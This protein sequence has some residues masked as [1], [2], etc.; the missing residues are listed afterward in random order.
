MDTSVGSLTD[1]YWGQF[2][3]CAPR[4][5][6]V[7]EK[8]HKSPQLT[9]RFLNT[10]SLL[11]HIGFRKILISR[12]KD[13]NAELNQRV[14]RHLAE[15]SRHSFFFK[16]S[17]ENFAKR[18]LNFSDTELLAGPAARAYLGR[19]DARTSREVRGPLKYYYMSLLVEIRAVWVYRLY[20]SVL[21]DLGLRLNLNSILAEE[22][23]H[24]QNM[25]FDL[26]KRDKAMKECLHRLAGYEMSRFG[27]FLRALE[28]EC[29]VHTE[30]STAAE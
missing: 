22:Q 12:A 7:L 15:E 21:S 30:A 24:L 1:Q 23:M 9:Y 18:E 8:I 20:K 25:V 19:L 2:Q 16:R 3:F 29:L 4:L 11:E 6:I 5:R 26:Y 14:L 13:G 17:A 27:V 28:R 10:L